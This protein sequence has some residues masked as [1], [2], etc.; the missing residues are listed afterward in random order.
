M[1]GVLGEIMHKKN[2]KRELERNRR[3]QKRMIQ[4]IIFNDSFNDK[5]V[6]ELVSKLDRI[7]VM[8]KIKGCFEVHL[9]PDVEKG[10]VLVDLRG[11]GTFQR[12]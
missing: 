11:R 12:E 5:K 3:F 6:C 8:G 4:G 9:V 1:S 2:V 10:E 7:E